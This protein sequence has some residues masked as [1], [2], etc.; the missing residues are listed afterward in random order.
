MLL[1]AYPSAA[2]AVSEHD[3][4]HLRV[5]EVVTLL[6]EGIAA[7]VWE[8]WQG[9]PLQRGLQLQMACGGGIQ[10]VALVRR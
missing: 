9:H 1:Q 6:E 8:R 10:L 3:G 5:P 4:M 2:A 7:A